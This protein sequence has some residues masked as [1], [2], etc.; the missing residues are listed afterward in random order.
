MTARAAQP[1]DKPQPSTPPPLAGRKLLL[2]VTGGIAAFKC[3]YLIRD[4]RRLGVEVQVVLTEA[5]TKFVAPLTFATLSGRRAPSELFPEP[6]PAEPIH[7]TLA[8]HSNLMLVAP[9]SADFI[10]KMALG[11][12]DDL[13]SSVAL[14]YRGPVLIAPAMNSAMWENPAVKSNVATLRKRGI[15]FVGPE[16]G[17]LAGISEEAGPGR[18]SEPAAILARI[19]ELLGGAKMAGLRVLVASGPTR[20][21]LDPVRFISNYSSGRMGD[22]VARQAILQGADVVLVHG[23][24]AQRE[25]PLGVKLIPVDS[26]AEMAQAVKAEFK[27]CHLLVMAAAVA[28]WRPKRPAR[29][30]LK[31]AAGAP[32]L[33]WEETEDILRWAGANK[34]GQVV[35]GFALE[36]DAH[37]ENARRKLEGKK[38]DLMALND[39]TEEGSGFGGD[40]IRLTLLPRNGKPEALPILPKWAAAHRLLEAAVRLLKSR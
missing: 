12:A 17:E 33:E 8:H 5:A 16:K 31:K 26:A 29:D 36:T 19:E 6:P 7:L 2:V 25:P 39:P 21:P 3:C 24:G 10:G 35:V 22:A 4:L 14:A 30:K 1:S 28:D 23:R 11:L 13:A 15:Q 32:R 40:T 38:A 9:A 27:R 20:E 34:R 37:L 18:M